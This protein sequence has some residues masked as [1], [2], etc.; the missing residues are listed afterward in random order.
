MLDNKAQVDCYVQFGL[1]F[2]Q[3]TDSINTIIHQARRGPLLSLMAM[4]R[5]PLRDKDH[6]ACPARNDVMH[7]VI[8][9]A[10]AG[11]VTFTAFTLQNLLKELED[12]NIIDVTY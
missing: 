5:R 4:Q 12:L 2:T 8:S 3:C 9:S 11:R 10:N 7:T 1:T 6:R